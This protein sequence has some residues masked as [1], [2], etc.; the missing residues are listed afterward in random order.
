MA[1]PGGR[2]WVG[3]SGPAFVYEAMECLGGN[4]YIEDGTLARLYREA[5]V[6]AIW[7]GSG[8]VVCLD[9]LRAFSR[10]SEA[11]RAVIAALA[12]EAA[13]LAGT[14][15]AA[16]LIEKTLAEADHEATARAAVERLALLAAAAALKASA[17]A[18]VSETFARARLAQ[19]AP[20]TYGASNLEAA[21]T[22]LIER[23]LP[24]N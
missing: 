22:T 4:G 9:V 14:R 7:E 21:A 16:A 15:E 19:R 18:D 17:P 6:N 23:V 20:L 3:K 13:D 5:P 8:N 1:T 11:V 12:R 24:A 10:E 2:Y